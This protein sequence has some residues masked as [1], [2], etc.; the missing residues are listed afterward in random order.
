MLLHVLEQELLLLR[1]DRLFVEL[2]SPVSIPRGE[3]HDLPNIQQMI[4]SQLSQ[5]HVVWK[6]EAQCTTQAKC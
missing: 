6:S 4:K 2:E 3:G 1:T 5:E